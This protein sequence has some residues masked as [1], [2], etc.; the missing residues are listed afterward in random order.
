[1]WVA[2]CSP[3]PPPAA[4][5]RWD[6]IGPQQMWPFD[7]PAKLA[8]LARDVLPDVLPA[9]LS[10]LAGAWAGARFAF[11]YETRTDERR[12]REENLAAGRRALFSLGH[13][14]S[15]IN[16]IRKS[17]D[18]ETWANDPMS[19]WRLPA[20]ETP[21]RP[22]KLDLESLHFLLEGDSAE[23]LNK[24][25]HGQWV[26]E[27][28]YGLVDRRSHYYLEVFQPILGKIAHGLVGPE[29]SSLKTLHTE[30]ELDLN[31]AIAGRLKTDTQNLF[32]SLPETV[33]AVWNAH[34][35]LRE[36]LLPMFPEARIAHVLLHEP[37]R[38]Y[39]TPSESPSPEPSSAGDKA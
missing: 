25:L 26:F 20:I 8:A 12:R 35:R 14:L 19:W 16:V 38:Q 31:P 3:A 27:S 29:A 18:L 24:L 37:L 5:L 23:V 21:P 28:F 15:C 9:G 32:D 30:L 39:V 1:M 13:H 33:Q 4:V 11:R 36:T 10:A 22:P 17:L 34:E 2:P 6:S 7:D